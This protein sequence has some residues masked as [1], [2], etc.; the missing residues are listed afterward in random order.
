MRLKKPR[1]TDPQKDVMRDIPSICQMHRRGRTRIDKI[2]FRIGSE[3]LLSLCV[4]RQPTFLAAVVLCFHLY[5]ENEERSFSG[6][7]NIK[8]I[9]RQQPVSVFDF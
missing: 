9:C 7:R 5:I 8:K 4:V 6:Q 1:I 3:G 2:D